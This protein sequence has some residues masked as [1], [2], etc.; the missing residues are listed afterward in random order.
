MKSF[1]GVPI[2]GC[3]YVNPGAGPVEDADENYARM[4]VRAFIRDLELDGVWFRR[5]VRADRGDGRFCYRLYKGEQKCEILV[6]GLPLKQV[7]F[8]DGLDPW[9]FPRLYV[10]GSS[11]LW[12]YAVG[13]A[14]HALTASA[15]PRAGEGE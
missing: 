3:I 1:N 6:P 9:D 15:R 5:Y 10:D 12:I 13:R 8:Q 11:W 14:R 2:A 4:N 7:R